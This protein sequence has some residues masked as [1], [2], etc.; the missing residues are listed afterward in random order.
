MKSLHSFVA[1]A[2]LCSTLSSPPAHAASYL[3]QDL[4]E[5]NSRVDLAIERLSSA[6]FNTL[7][8]QTTE[9]MTPWTSAI[10]DLTASVEPTELDELIR[11]GADAALS[12]PPEVAAF[13]AQEVKAAYDKVMPDT[14]TLIPLP[15]IGSKA[16]PFHSRLDGAT[17]Q[18][19]AERWE[20]VWSA[21]PKRQGGVC[22]VPTPLAMERLVRVQSDA[23]KA[24]DEGKVR[25][26]SDQLQVVLKS[27]PKSRG[28]K[29]FSEVAKQQQAALIRAPF[30]DRDRLKKAWPEYLD[31]FRYRAQ[32][33]RQRAQGPPKCFTIGCK[34]FYEYDIWRYDTKNDYTG[35]GLEKPDRA[36]LKPAPWKYE[37][38]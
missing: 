19:M 14:C 10:S 15:A 5:A 8:V 24:S 21:V 33:E 36:I 20:S 23:L 27:I 38:P 7:K 29:L 3:E 9:S 28:F 12:V 35:E 16:N 4:S 31:A 30:A 32:L 34:T 2:L 1:G 25:A 13:T 17:S 26:V 6:V 22:M 37:P 18:A 11:R